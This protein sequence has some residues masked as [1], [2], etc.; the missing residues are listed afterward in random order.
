MR[1]KRKNDVLSLYNPGDFEREPCV[2]FANQEDSLGDDFR[3]EFR[4]DY[5]RLLHSSCFRRLQGKTQLFPGFESD[6]FR[7]RLTHSLEVA[8]IAKGLAIHLNATAPELRKKQNSID[9]D[10]VEFAALAHD[11][12]HPPFGHNGEAELHSLMSKNYGYE[13]NAQTLRIV[14]TLEKRFLKTENVKQPIG[15]KAEDLR[16]GLSLTYRSLASILKYDTSIPIN[17]SADE[18]LKGYYSYDIDLVKRI[19]EN[20]TGKKN[21]GDSFKTLECY[22]MDVADDIAYSTYDFEDSLQA[23]FLNILDIFSPRKDV[24]NIVAEKVN[25]NVRKVGIDKT[26]TAKDILAIY[27]TTIGYVLNEKEL[28]EAKLPNDSEP[29]LLQAGRLYDNLKKLG[30]DGYFRTN[31]TSRLVH[32]FVNGIKLDYNKDIPALSKVYLS[33]SIREE[34]EVLKNL[35]FVSQIESPKLKISSFRGREIVNKIFTAIHG[36]HAGSELLPEDF[37]RVYNLIPKKHP[38]RQRV[39]IDFIAG[40]TDRYAIEFYGRLTSENPQTIFKPL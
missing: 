7:N 31:V 28:L 1:A 20:V 16:V 23:G 36:T 40:M 32:R 37:R 22:L 19:K 38:Y 11:L 17:S 18:P 29:F 25:R 21:F 5:G 24:I 34:V 8:Q 30:E 33:A 6:F 27:F 4:K 3:S 2:P 15:P 26:Y 13:G 9:L 39:V 35:V 14:S 10:L 12:G